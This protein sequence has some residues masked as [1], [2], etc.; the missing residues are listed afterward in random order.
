MTP[1]NFAN[2]N[3]IEISYMIETSYMCLIKAYKY[4]ETLG[5]L[6]LIKNHRKQVGKQGRLLTPADM[7]VSI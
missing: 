4:K 2:T 1:I 6:S 5:I 7:L 3:I